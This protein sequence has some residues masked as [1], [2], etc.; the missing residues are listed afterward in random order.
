MIES[1][2]IRNFRAFERVDLHDLKRVNIVVGRNATG[3]TALGEAIYLAASAAPYGAWWIRL[4]RSRLL[5]QQQIFWDRTLFEALW[6]DLF[7]DFDQDEKITLT[8]KDTQK[9]EYRVRVFYDRSEAK[10]QQGVGAAPTPPIFPL[11]FERTGPGNLRTINKV[12]LEKGAPSYE[13]QLEFIPRMAAIPS[14]NPLNQQEVVSWY[15][16]LIKAGKEEPVVKALQEVFPQVRD[17]SI[18]QDATLSALYAKVPSIRER[19]PIG[20]VSS[21]IAKLLS[22]LLAVA[23][24][25]DGVVMVDEIENGIHYERLP[26]VWATLFKFCS[27]NKVQLFAATHSWECLKAISETLKDQET[28]F[29][30]LRTEKEDG[31]CTVRQFDGKR[32]EAALDE[33]VDIR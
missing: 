7:Y 15:S 23:D 18:A 32:L 22:I 4:S 28:D 8:F 16:E 5:P 29:C 13:G 30:L 19:L 11:V 9:G 14:T 2:S 21:G 25:R 27:E 20:V 24:A 1:F 26:A 33:D 3:K 31:S 6:K 17:L 10:A 12:T